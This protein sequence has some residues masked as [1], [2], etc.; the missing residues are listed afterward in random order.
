[1]EKDSILLYLSIKILSTFFI[2]IRILVLIFLL[3]NFGKIVWY[4]SKT[5]NDLMK[6]RNGQ[7][8]GGLSN[9]NYAIIYL[10]YFLIFL[11]FLMLILINTISVNLIFDFEEKM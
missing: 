10:I 2:S 11:R 8:K 3:Y 6:A 5:K 4:I 9:L 1:M 7:Q